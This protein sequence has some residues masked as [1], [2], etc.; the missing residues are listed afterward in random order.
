MLASRVGRVIKTQL[1]PRTS[2]AGD[3]TVHHLGLVATSTQPTTAYR[4]LHEVSLMDNVP[5]ILAGWT[6]HRSCSSME[7]A[8]AW[9]P[10]KSARRFIFWGAVG[11]E[12]LWR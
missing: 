1:L 10:E 9:D 2:L 6:G 3:A 4:A 7:I 12:D 5:P 8:V 11:A